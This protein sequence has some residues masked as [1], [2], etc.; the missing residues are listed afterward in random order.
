MSARGVVR[1]VAI[2]FNRNILSATGM[3]IMVTSS[4]VTAV[5]NSAC[6]SPWPASKPQGNTSVSNRA[7]MSS[8]RMMGAAKAIINTR[9]VDF[10]SILVFLRFRGL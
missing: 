8:E 4:M 3:A 5:K 1:R 9:C 6:P 10:I 7:T 2:N